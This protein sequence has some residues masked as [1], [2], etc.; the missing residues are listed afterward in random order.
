MALGGDRKQL[1]LT[2]IRVALAATMFIHGIARISHGAVDDFGVFLNTLSFTFGMGFY[3]AWAITIFELVGG[4]ALAVGYFA[5]IVA[6][7]FALQLA[8]GIY[9]VHSKSGWFVV[10]LGNNGMEYSVMLIV[11][12][13]A[14]A[15]SHYGKKI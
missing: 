15:I 4:V 11:G 13:I 3:I 5:Y 6:I 9:L 8:M 1:A 10:G 14:I 12:F 7:I 2:L